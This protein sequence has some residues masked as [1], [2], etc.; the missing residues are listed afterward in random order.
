MSTFAKAP[1]S[2]DELARLVFNAW[3][4]ALAREGMV[5]GHSGPLDYL[6][7]AFFEDRRGG[8]PADCIVWANRGGGKTL[9]GALATA[10]DMI[11][12]PGIAIR[13]LGGSKEQSRRMF[14]HLSRLFEHEELK[15]TVVKETADRIA[16][17]NG[18]ECEVLAQSETSVRGVRI[19]KLR[20]DEVELFSREVWDAAQLTTRSER[21][22]G[23]NVRGGIECFS[24]MHEPGGLMTELVG[25][26]MAGRRRLFKWSIVDTLGR[27]EDE[28][29]CGHERPEE[30]RCALFAECG[31]RLKERDK[32]GLPAGHISVQDAIDQK[33][34]VSLAVWEAEMLCLK[35]NYTH[36]VY[37]EFSRDRHVVDELPADRTGWRYRA[38]MDFGLRGATVILWAGLD[39]QGAVWVYDEWWATGAVLR[40]SIAE[41]LRR[42]PRPEW[43]AID[44]AGEGRETQSGTSNAAVMR[45]HGIR[46]R[47]YRA[48]IA[49]GLEAVRW[50]LSPGLKTAPPIL[51]VTRKCHKLIESL[52]TYRY[53]SNRNTEQPQKDGS[54]HAA[55]ALRYLCYA[56]DA[57]RG[58]TTTMLKY[59]A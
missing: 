29:V 46:T 34:R 1:T 30:E 49:R 33:K 57:E 4:Y 5:E 22:E 12:K 47:A 23:V 32:A 56:L 53:P 19:Q 36:L 27:C 42:Q 20:C 13:I 58:G 21:L 35:P 14:S 2:R 6:E 50:R 44:P 37:P 59:V 15:D 31:G 7:H 11:F 28:R 41:I 43:V 52:E 54:D 39:W 3:G 24:T 25:S 26:A 17:D 9:L 40:V 16:L 10:L 18:S 55:D 8:E 48:P 38:G 51:R 45:E